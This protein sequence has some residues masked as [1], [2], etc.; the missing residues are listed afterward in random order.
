MADNAAMSA[1]MHGKDQAAPAF[2][3]KVIHQRQTFRQP[4]SDR[5]FREIRDG[6]AS[7]DTFSDPFV[8]S[9]SFVVSSY[10]R[11]CIF[12]TRNVRIARS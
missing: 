2:G 11:Q 3:H 12:D 5:P 10:P 9:V 1:V 6:A 4:L 8:L 7:N